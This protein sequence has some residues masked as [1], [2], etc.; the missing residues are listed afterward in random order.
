MSN[1]AAYAERKCR[2]AGLSVQSR[3]RLNSG[4]A[5]VGGGEKSGV[6][7]REGVK[8]RG[9]AWIATSELSLHACASTG[10]GGRG[11]GL[12][13]LDQSS[14]GAF[15]L[16]D[17]YA[18]FGVKDLAVE[19]R[20]LDPVV[21]EDCDVTCGAFSSS[22]QFSIQSLVSSPTPAAVK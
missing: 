5:R 8:A 16:V 7:K 10:D 13:G 12:G 17:T 2:V 4:L 15:C 6:V 14:T 3:M 18:S 19:V 11:A 1:A 21:I 20:E 9:R 22:S